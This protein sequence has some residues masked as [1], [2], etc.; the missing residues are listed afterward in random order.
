[1]TLIFR[2]KSTKRPD[3]T[4]VKTPSIPVLL[5]GVDESFQIVALLDSGADVSV[6]SKDLAELLKLDLKKDVR[7]SFGIGGPVNSVESE[8][9]L[10]IEKDHEKYSF[11]IPLLVILDEYSLPPL[12]G[13]NGFFNHFKI[14][15]DQENQKVILKKNQEK[16]F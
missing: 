9:K 11:K 12:L 8:V 14:S 1:M 5:S 10:T 4:F 2:Y 16:R 13:R 6:I 15:F 7:K 3:G